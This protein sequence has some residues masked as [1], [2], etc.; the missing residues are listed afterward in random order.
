MVITG[1][2]V[3][4]DQV[5]RFNSVLF[6]TTWKGKR[7]TVIVNICRIILCKLRGSPRQGEDAVEGR[8]APSPAGYTNPRSN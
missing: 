4:H 2:K 6:F 8:Q 3:C 5:T 1:R 7:S